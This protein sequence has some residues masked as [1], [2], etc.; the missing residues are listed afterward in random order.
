MCLIIRGLFNNV[1]KSGKRLLRSAWTLNLFIVLAY[2]ETLNLKTTL[3]DML[4]GNQNITLSI[5]NS[6]LLR[7]LNPKPLVV[8]QELWMTWR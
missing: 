1:N 7:S 8:A 3:R 2:R 6:W 4:C 5:L